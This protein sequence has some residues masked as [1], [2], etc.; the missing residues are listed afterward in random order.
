MFTMPCFIAVQKQVGQ[1]FYQKELEMKQQ[2]TIPHC[3]ARGS[4]MSGTLDVRRRSVSESACCFP[5]QETGC[6]WDIGCLWVWLEKPLT[7]E[8]FPQCS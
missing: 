7:L 3:D 1:L 6:M 5:P 4:V 8:T 2:I